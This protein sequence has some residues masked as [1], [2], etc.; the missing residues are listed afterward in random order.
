MLLLLE[1]FSTVNSVS[2]IVIRFFFCVDLSFCLISSGTASTNIPCFLSCQISPPPHYFSLLW[3]PQLY[4][5]RPSYSVLLVISFHIHLP[6]VVFTV[7]HSRQ[8]EH[9][10]EGQR[11]INYAREDFRHGETWT[12]YNI[13]FTGFPEGEGGQWSKSNIWNNG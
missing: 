10:P 9:S 7:I 5:V 13:Q 1:S 2:L 8:T 6:S 12:S 4:C 11:D 3:K